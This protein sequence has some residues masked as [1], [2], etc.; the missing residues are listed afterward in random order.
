MKAAARL[1]E[2]STSRRVVSFSPISIFALVGWLDVSP[3]F[4]ATGTE[5][6]TLSF[7]II[8]GQ[9][10][11]EAKVDVGKWSRR[12]RD[13]T[14]CHDP[15]LE[16]AR[17]NKVFNDLFPCSICL[18]FRAHLLS[19]RRNYFGPRGRSV[20][21]SIDSFSG[22][23]LKERIGATSISAVNRP[24]LLV[25]VTRLADRT[26]NQ[27]PHRPARRDSLRRRNTGRRTNH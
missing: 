16:C 25:H 20:L 4:W 8:A 2:R 11:K 10:E 15:C 27:S 22:R 19:Y 13:A 12:E 26:V 17:G 23:P 7:F 14:Y 18:L 21:Y 6:R 1:V 3:S 24:A 5:A 9:L